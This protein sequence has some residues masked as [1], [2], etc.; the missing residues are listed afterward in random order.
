MGGCRVPAGHGGSVLSPEGLHCS[1]IGKDLLLARMHAAS[2][3]HGVISLG[4]EF[5]A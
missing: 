4:G 3:I 1:H 2:R 5:T